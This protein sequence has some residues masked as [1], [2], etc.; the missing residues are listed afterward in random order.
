MNCMNCR[1][2]P[3]LP[4]F[5]LFS[6]SLFVRTSCELGENF[7]EKL[8]EKLREIFVIVTFFGFSHK[9]FCSEKCSLVDAAV[10]DEISVILRT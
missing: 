7:H 10:C 5:C 3:S 9:P 8:G 4:L 1:H 6:L 2:H